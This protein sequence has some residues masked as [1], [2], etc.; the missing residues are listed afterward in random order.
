MPLKQSPRIHFAPFIAYGASKTLKAE[1]T[2]L[3]SEVLPSYAHNLLMTK[4]FEVIFCVAYFIPKYHWIGAW[5][6]FYSNA[7]FSCPSTWQ[8]YLLTLLQ[9]AVEVEKRTQKTPHPLSR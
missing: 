7:L 3:C 2:C 1:F 6:N 5:G 8:M 9:L 4:S